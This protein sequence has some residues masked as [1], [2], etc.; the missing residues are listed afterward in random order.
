MVGLGHG[1]SEHIGL[2][3]CDEPWFET[4]TSVSD[5]ALLV[6]GVLEPSPSVLDELD[7]LLKH[8]LVK[9][10]VFVM[11]PLRS[12]PELEEQWTRAREIA[13]GRGLTSR[14]AM[15]RARCLR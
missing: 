12:R 9:K 8:G 15:P 10:T 4:F 6:I 7:Y 1:F 11:P 3:E 14:R 13:A 5:R 2:I